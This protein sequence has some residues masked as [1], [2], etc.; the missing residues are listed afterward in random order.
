MSKHPFRLALYGPRFR[1]WIVAALVPLLL[2]AQS[3]TAAYL[4]PQ[5]TQALSQSASMPVYCDQAD[6]DQP[7]LCRA[8][9]QANGQASGSALDFAPAMLAFESH[10]AW[11][12]PARRMIEAP[13]VATR[14]ARPRGSPPLY[15]L[16]MVLR[17]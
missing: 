10:P 16:Y 13:R 9:C 14:H 1:R 8:H 15:L 6:P 5:L 17:D 3:A 4:C 2:F 12:L 11:R 7:T